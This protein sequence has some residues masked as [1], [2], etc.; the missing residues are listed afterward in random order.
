MNSNPRILAWCATALILSGCG[1]KG[2]L[3][4]PPPEQEE[5]QASASNAV[6]PPKSVSLKK[7]QQQKNQSGVQ[8]APLQ[9]VPPTSDQPK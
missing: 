4:F 8:N 3:Y 6:K 1:L 5:G 2:P 7:S 9:S